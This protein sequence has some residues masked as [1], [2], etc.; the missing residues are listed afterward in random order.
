MSIRLR[1]TTLQTTTGSSVPADGVLDKI[2]KLIPSQVIAF[3]TAALVWL[4][5]TA[6]E[7][8]G[9]ASNAGHSI[10]SPDPKL[11]IP[12]VLG[13]GLTPLLTWRQ[14][15]EENKPPAYLQIALATGSFVVWAFATGGPFQYLSFWSKGIAAVV[16]AA[17][18]VFLGLF[19]QK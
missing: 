2:V 11:W 5:P 4:A 10:T 12:F 14:T 8:G 3:Y 1:R 7:A 19:P 18:T 13:F 16:L 9:A 15:T 17:Y 6:T